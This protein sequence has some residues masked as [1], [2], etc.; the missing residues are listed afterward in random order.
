MY[1]I[2]SEGCA[3]KLFCAGGKKRFKH[4]C[5][6]IGRK[7]FLPADSVSQGYPQRIWTE[8]PICQ[9]VERISAKV[10]P[11]DLFGQTEKGV[12]FCVLFPEK[13]SRAGR[14]ADIQANEKGYGK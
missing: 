9:A 14:S 5:K 4:N 8:S 11:P 6:G 1:K 7:R 12:R 13:M 10:C 3:K 2:F